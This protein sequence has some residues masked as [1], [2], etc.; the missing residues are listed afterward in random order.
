[1]IICKVCQKEVPRTGACQKYCKPC[2]KKVKNQKISAYYFNV[3]KMKDIRIHYDVKH[4]LICGSDILNLGEI[5]IC[6][7]CLS[8]TTNDRQM[9]GARVAR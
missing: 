1:M 9:A 4:C 2:G 6:L 7:D 3:T 5:K 8:V